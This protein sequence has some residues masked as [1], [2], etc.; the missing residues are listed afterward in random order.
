MKDQETIV[1]M[2]SPDYA[3][4]VLKNL[5]DHYTVSAVVTQPDQPVGRGKM[6]QAPP[7]KVIAESLGLP[8][9]Q[10]GK[11]KGEEF[12]R[13]LAEQSPDAIVVAAYGKI[14]PRPVL[15]FPKYGCVNVHASLLPRWR[16][17]SPI[18]SA[19]LNGDKQS[20]VTIMVM[21]EGVDTGPTLASCKVEIR[22]EETTETL[23]RALAETGAD[24]L[25]QILPDYFSG[26]LEANPQPEQGA[27]YTRLLKKEDGLMDFSHEAEYL[28]RQVRACI[29]WPGAF[30]EWQN[31]PLRVWKAE[32]MKSCTLKTGQ[33]GIVEKFPI[34]GTASSDLKLLEVQPA[35][36]KVM[37]GCDF[38]NGARNWVD[39]L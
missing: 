36:K 8:V 17:A 25:V 21:D 20:G 4:P 37:R 16:G 28:E 34:I 31:A 27:T 18:H 2:G 38:L 24:L 12:L 35:G 14:L 33:R 6:I 15:D 5:S 9:F 11:V 26:R 29:P 22:E 1:F 32:V 7:V 19:I 10:P 3:V 39:C 30:M 13:F 23:T